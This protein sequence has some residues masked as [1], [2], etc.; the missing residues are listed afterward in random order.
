MRLIDLRSHVAN[1]CN[2][3]PEVTAYKTEI[4]RLLNAAYAELYDGR[5]WNFAQKEVHTTVYADRSATDGTVTNGSTTVTTA[6]AFFTTDMTGMIM[7]GPDGEEY[8]IL[9]RTNSTTIVL[10]SDYTGT[11]VAG[12]AT[13]IIKQR[14]IDLPSDCAKVLQVGRRPVTAETSPNPGRFTPLARTEGEWWD[15]PLNET[16]DP[17]AWVPYDDA[18]VVAPVK[19]PVLAAVAG[20]WAAGTYEFRYVYVKQER[21]SAFSPA[22][23]ITLTA[24]QSPN[25]TYPN[26]GTDS[27]IFKQ[28]YIRYGDF[29]D[30]RRYTVSNVAETT[31]TVNYGTAPSDATEFAPRHPGNDGT[32]Q[33]LMLYPRQSTTM[34]VT[35]RYLA[36]PALMVE[37]NDAPSFP[38]GE[39]QYLVYRALYDIFIKHD[40]PSYAKLY[41]DK[42][43][44]AM[45]RLQQR[46]LATEAR[47]WV[48]GGFD[49][50]SLYRRNPFGPLRYTP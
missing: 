46:Y 33:R 17:E 27:G 20:A 15:L 13:I 21:Y 40:Q 10:T 18:I 50:D 2:Y 29:K 42:A 25:V 32:T 31:T 8:E 24:G 16:G 39:H 36:R 5:E 12:T 7:E 35:I 4:D 48:K 49:G 44:G 45:L 37:D 9:K 3:D 23:S 41:E 30:W 26:T 34:E 6:A 14:Y 28:L 11:T 43:N 38:A 22:A 47:R 19:A 1:I